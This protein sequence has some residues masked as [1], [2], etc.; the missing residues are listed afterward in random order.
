MEFLLRYHANLPRRTRRSDRITG[1]RNEVIRKARNRSTAKWR[2]S[3]PSMTRNVIKAHRNEHR[4]EHRSRSPIPSPITRSI[5]PRV[6]A[7]EL[8]YQHVYDVDN[9][10]VNSLTMNPRDP[11]D[12]APSIGILISSSISCP[13]VVLVAVQRLGLILLS[14]LP[15]SIFHQQT[16]ISFSSRRYHEIVESLRNLIF[17]YL[18]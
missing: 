11:P 12:K 4:N 16:E 10:E 18:S 1:G 5:S 17:Q 9:D 15:C 13:S 2:L 6:T 3:A 7:H 8:N 14:R